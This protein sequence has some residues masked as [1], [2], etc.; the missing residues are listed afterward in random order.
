MLLC[1]FCLL[2][3]VALV[4]FIG[5]DATVT[6]IVTDS[7]N[8]LV[9]GVAIEIGNTEANHSRGVSTNYEGNYTITSLPPGHYKLTAELAVFATGAPLTPVAADT[10]LNLGESKPNSIGKGVLD[11]TPPCVPAK[12]ACPADP[13]GFKPFVYGNSGR[14][15]LD[16]PAFRFNGSNHS[17][18]QTM[19]AGGRG[20]NRVFQA[21]LKFELR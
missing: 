2:G 10:N 19:A 21:G 9:S 20:G 3:C 5:Q 7:A 11:D 12:V 15:I 16:G 8:T 1:Q 18:D 6:G 17:G 14:N 13:Y 4:P